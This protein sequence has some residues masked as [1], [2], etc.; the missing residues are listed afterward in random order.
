MSCANFDADCA[1]PTTGAFQVL[2]MWN[3]SAWEP[4]GDSGTGTGDDV[5][6]NDGSI[7]DPNLQDSNDIAITNPLDLDVQFALKTDSVRADEIEAE[8]KANATHPD[9]VTRVQHR[10]RYNDSDTHR[11]HF[12]SLPEM[13]WKM[14]K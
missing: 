3:G 13:P 4:T 10:E 12:G 6:L 5:T 8:L 2:C 9:Q 11:Y 14:E 7:T 1:T